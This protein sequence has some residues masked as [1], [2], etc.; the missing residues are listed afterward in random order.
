MIHVASKIQD[1]SN[2]K[3][4]VHIVVVPPFLNA[5]VIHAYIH[6]TFIFCL[7]KKKSLSQIDHQNLLHFHPIMLDVNEWEM[8]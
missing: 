7:R 3:G 4:N 2:F 5:T 1:E 8:I 6:H